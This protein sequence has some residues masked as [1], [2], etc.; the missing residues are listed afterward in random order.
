MRYIKLPFCWLDEEKR[1]L[2][3]SI[4]LNPFAIEAYHPSVLDF[5]DPDEGTPMSQ[6]ITIVNTRA[7]ISYEILMKIKD[8]EKALDMFM[9]Q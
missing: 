3:T 1:V 2:S 7:G 4:R 6:D 9:A 8:F 5:I